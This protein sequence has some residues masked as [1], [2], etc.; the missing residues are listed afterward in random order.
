MEGRTVLVVGETPSLGRSIVDL[1]DSGDV[2]NRLVR[3]VEA[4]LPLASL[5]GRFQLVIAA[6]NQ[7]WCATARRWARGECPDLTLVVVGSRDPDLPALPG[8]RVVPLPLRPA[9][10]LSLVRSLIDSSDL[11]TETPRAGSA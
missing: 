3:N 5:S 10:F 8:V 4:E 1:L 2:P 11:S 6:C 7:R 9:R